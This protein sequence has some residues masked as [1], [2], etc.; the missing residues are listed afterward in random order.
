MTDVHRLDDQLCFALH[1]ATRAITG[2]YQPLLESLA[3]TYP[4]YLVLLVLWEEDGAR[5]SRIGQRLYLDSATLTPLLK[6]LAARGLVERRRSVTDER[7]VEV[8][9]TGD[10]KLLKRR[11]A[12]LPKLLFAKTKLSPTELKQLRSNL[13]E[14][15]RTLHRRD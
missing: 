10:G 12:E 9:L 11:A 2:A 4:Q 8:Y 6:R 14:L 15:T 7:V 5:V 3:V 1:A 13:Q